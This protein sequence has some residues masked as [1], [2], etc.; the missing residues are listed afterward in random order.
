MRMGIGLV[1]MDEFLQPVMGRVYMAVGAD[2]EAV[3]GRHLEMDH[4]GR[5][6]IPTR[7][8]KTLGYLRTGT[9]DHADHVVI[10]IAAH[11]EQG[12]QRSA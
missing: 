12:E 10:R 7:V 8:L 11:A 1:G 3:V 2:K 9:V 5:V 4:A 6:A